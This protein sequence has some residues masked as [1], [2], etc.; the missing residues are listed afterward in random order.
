LPALQNASIAI[1]SRA[2]MDLD[3]VAIPVIVIAVARQ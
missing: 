3:H 2:L 1:C